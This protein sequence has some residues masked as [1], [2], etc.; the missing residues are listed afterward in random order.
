MNKK[1]WWALGFL[2][3]VYMFAFNFIA[4]T[5]DVAIVSDVSAW[6]ISRA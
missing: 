1:Q 6:S 2:F 5:Y 4:R 3:M